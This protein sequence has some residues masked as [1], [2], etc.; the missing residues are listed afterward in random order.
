MALTA[1]TES[2]LAELF[3]AAIVALTPR[4]TYKGAEGWKPYSREVAGAS[5]TRRF[6]L[7]WSP[8]TIQPNGAK[9]LRVME[10][11]AGLRVRTD[12]CGD[13]SETQYLMADDF[14]QLAD[15]LTALKSSSTPNGLVLV[16]PE[17]WEAAD[18]ADD[19]STDVTKID[20]RFRVRFMRLISP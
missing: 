11:N 16:E 12:Y 19:D 3:V 17:T 9:A 14:W 15:A 8:G 2:E 5:T 4:L 13:H 7:V 10:I 18:A 1:T 20:H 6:R